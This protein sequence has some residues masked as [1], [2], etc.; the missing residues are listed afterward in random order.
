MPRGKFVPKENHSLKASQVEAGNITHQSRIKL[1]KSEN[2]FD[3]STQE[4]LLHDF[5]SDSTL[6]AKATPH[7]SLNFAFTFLLI[8]LFILIN[9]GLAVLMTGNTKPEPV[10]KKSEGNRS[11]VEESVKVETAVL[12]PQPETA[13]PLTPAVIQQESKPQSNQSDSDLLA[14]ISKE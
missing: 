12:P 3:G 5:S 8:M 2:S 6:S 1:I 14:I 10:E 7:S 13:A 4:D 11:V 9:I